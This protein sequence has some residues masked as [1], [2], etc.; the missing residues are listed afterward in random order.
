MKMSVETAPEHT[1]NRLWDVAIVG[2]GCAGIACAYALARRDPTL[3]IALFDPAQNIPAGVPFAHARPE[4][5]LNVRASQLSIR[6]DLPM[7]F[8]E[9]L[10]QTQGALASEVHNQFASR[11]VYA[12]YLSARVGDA[13][14]MLADQGALVHITA[15]V[16]RLERVNRLERVDTQFLLSTDAAPQRARRVILALGAGASVPMLCHPHWHQGPWRLRA[17]P[18][19]DAAARALVIGSGLTGVDSVQSLRTLGWRGEIHWLAPGARLPQCSVAHENPLWQWPSGF[20]NDI[21]SPRELLT[22]LRAQMHMAVAQ[23]ADWRSVIDALR[24]HTQH[25]FSAW[26]VRE[27]L[28]VLKRLGSI[29][30][31]HRHRAAPVMAAQFAVWRADPK[32]KIIDA[33]ARSAQALSAQRCQVQLDREGIRTTDTYSLVIDARGPNYRLQCWPLVTKLVQAGVLQASATG[34]GLAVD[35]NGRAGEGVFALG[36][37]GYGERLETTAVPELRVQAE[38]IAAIIW[39]Q[40]DLWAEGSAVM[41]LT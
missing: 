39:A 34:L 2:G 10:Q 26:S 4:H 32:L 30:S 40:A 13:E 8:C 36:A 29:W 18:D 35:S 21:S 9:F 23:N 22:A 20:F 24:P 5:L 31:R 17:L 41:P 33:R 16:L 3:Q 11:Q 14:A 27:K 37:I 25:L 15:T 7:D 6:S 19:H 28:R 1:L 38:Q 12:R